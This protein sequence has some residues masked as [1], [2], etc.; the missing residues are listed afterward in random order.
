MAKWGH[1]FSSSRKIDI[2]P[3]SCLQYQEYTLI[4]Y[5]KYVLYDK[6]QNTFISWDYAS[7]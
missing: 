3:T 7:V 6:I 4:I 5:N 1:S 2:N